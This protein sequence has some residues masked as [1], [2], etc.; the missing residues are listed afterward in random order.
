MLQRLKAPLIAATIFL[1]GCQIPP[2]DHNG[3]EPNSQIFACDQLRSGATVGELITSEVER[4]VD[5]ESAQ[6]YVISSV[7]DTCPEFAVL[8]DDHFN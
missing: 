3:P 8:L 7:T 2:V 6:E 5:Q 1:A 4:G